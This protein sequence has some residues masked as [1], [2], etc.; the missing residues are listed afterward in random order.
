MTTHGYAITTDDR[1]AWEQRLERLPHAFFHTWDHCQAMAASTGARTYLWCYEDGESLACC[2]IAERLLDGTADVVTPLGFSG[3]TA[4]GP[5]PGLAA[6]WRSWCTERGYVCAYIALNP[7]FVDA[8]WFDPA[9]CA[10]AQTL[11][12]I[13]LRHGRDALRSGLQASL[14]HKLRFA[15]PVEHSDDVGKDEMARY[16]VDRFA[17]S[18]ATRGA[19]GVY[20]LAPT[21]IDALARSPHSFLLGVRGDARLES[22][23]LFGRSA[24]CGDAIFNVCGEAGRA[25]AFTLLWNGALRLQDEG[26][27]FLNLGGGIRE[28]DGVAQFKRRFGGLERPLLALRQIYDFERYRALCSSFNADAE[29]RDGYF[30][31]YRDPALLASG[32]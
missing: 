7:L 21:T 4:T 6:A 27:P 24:A 5:I 30:P 12:I 25:H 17:E 10:T 15:A 19:A 8:G 29:R 23:T 2:P 16:F 9:D 28:G 3:F 20:R 14:R 31:A 26:V 32:R 1:T 13:D 18:F 22:V 11:Y